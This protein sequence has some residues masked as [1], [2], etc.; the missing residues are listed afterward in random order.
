MTDLLEKGTIP[1]NDITDEIGSD[2]FKSWNEKIGPNYF[3]AI[4]DYLKAPKEKGPKVSLENHEK[5][6]LFYLICAGKDRGQNKIKSLQDVAVKAKVKFPGRVGGRQFRTFKDAIT[7]S[8]VSFAKKPKDQTKF[9][10]FDI[11]ESDDP[12]VNDLKTAI[13]ECAPFLSKI[14]NA[15]LKLNAMDMDNIIAFGRTNKRAQPLLKMAF[16]GK[17]PF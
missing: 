16:P 13:N 17:M 11:D 6:I 1:Q 2:E 9:I 4:A 8:G 10:K 15:L 12:W 3:P 5:F 7:D 14:N